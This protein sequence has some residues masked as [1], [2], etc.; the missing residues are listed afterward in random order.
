MIQAFA[1]FEPG[2]ELKPFE[3][4]PGEFQGQEVEIDVLYSGIC[5]SDLS[6]INN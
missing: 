6:L 5:H 2:G 1:A 3:Y 4:D